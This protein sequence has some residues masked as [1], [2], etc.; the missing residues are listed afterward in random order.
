M[1][2]NLQLH[3]LFC[4]SHHS[5]ETHTN[6]RDHLHVTQN[7]NVM[8]NTFSFIQLAGLTAGYTGCKVI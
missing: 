7:K 3:L 6:G 1:L 2:Y 5:I 4:K 8:K